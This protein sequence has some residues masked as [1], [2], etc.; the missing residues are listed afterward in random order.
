[1]FSPNIFRHFRV[2]PQA[3]QNRADWIGEFRDRPI[4]YI[5]DSYRLGQFPEEI[6]A[7]WSQHYVWYARSL[8]VAG[9][10]VAGTTEVD[11]IVPGIYRWDPHKASPAATL[12]LGGRTL[13]PGDETALSVG[14]LSAEAIGENVAGQLILADLPRPTRDGYPFFYLR[15]QIAQLGGYY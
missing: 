13:S 15:R 4:A 11:V 6:R 10:N 12:R 8:Y 2:S 9:F 7:F 14:T 5:V 1:M 3:M